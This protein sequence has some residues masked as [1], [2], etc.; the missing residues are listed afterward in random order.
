M[1]N[2]SMLEITMQHVVKNSSSAIRLTLES[3]S[4]LTCVTMTKLF[5]F[6]KSQF[7]LTQNGENKVVGLKSGRSTTAQ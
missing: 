5:N 7:A 3:T 2:F 4:L 6:P 1:T